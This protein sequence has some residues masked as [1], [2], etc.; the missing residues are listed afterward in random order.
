M[1]KEDVRIKELE[2]QLSTQSE[3]IAKLM[4]QIEQ[5]ENPDWNK[6]ITCIK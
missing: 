6:I 2:I 5:Q 1:G 4:Q 3:L